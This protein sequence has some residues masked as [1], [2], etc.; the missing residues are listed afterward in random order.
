MR[1]GRV[2]SSWHRPLAHSVTLDKSLNLSLL[3]FPIQKP[4]CVKFIAVH[5]R[6]LKVRDRFK[7]DNNATT[8]TFQYKLHSLDPLF[9]RLYFH[10]FKQ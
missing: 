3:P 9:L 5:W 6:L 10:S 2:L 7:V 1:Q 4:K 8:S